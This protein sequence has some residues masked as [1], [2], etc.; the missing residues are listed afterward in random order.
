MLGVTTYLTTDIASIPLLWV[1]PLSLYLLT[2]IFVFA[3]KKFLPLVVLSKLL[4]GVAVALIFLILT[5]VKN[6]AWLLL[7]LHLLFFFVAAMISHSPRGRPP[8]ERATD[9]VLPLPLDWRRAG[10]IVQRAARACHLR[11]RG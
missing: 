11:H 9:R 10:R 1:I 2:F 5:D 6:P 4:P 7:G 8:P 3:R